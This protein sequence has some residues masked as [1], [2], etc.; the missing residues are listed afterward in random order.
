MSML[1][2]DDPSAHATSV[3]HSTLTPSL[4]GVHGVEYRALLGEFVGCV[5][6]MV[7]VVGSG[8]A[9]QSLSPGNVG[10]ELLENALAIGAGLFVIINIVAPASGAHL[11]PV[12]SFADAWIG[13]CSWLRASLYLPFQ[14]AGCIVGT[15]VGN[16]MFGDAWVTWSNHHRASGAHFFSEIVATAGLIFLIFAL[17]RNGRRSLSAAAVGLYIFAACFATSS[18]TFANPAVTVARAFTNSFTGIAPSSLLVYI[19]GQL[20]GA[21]CG[22]AV[23]LLLYPRTESPTPAVVK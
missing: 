13:S 19:A 1:E 10:L 16:L 8:L 4:A 3:E 5:M 2:D 18:A 20:I 15:I 23:T 14:F 11:N 21:T 12:V 7:V 9:A 22:V 17:Q 6:L